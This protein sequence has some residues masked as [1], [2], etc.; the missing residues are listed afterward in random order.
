MAKVAPYHTTR[1][2]DPPERNVYHDYDN[3]P[4][5]SQIKPEH[6]ASGTDGRPRCLDCKAMD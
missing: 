4:A 3:C 6:K 2:E 1:L 5:G